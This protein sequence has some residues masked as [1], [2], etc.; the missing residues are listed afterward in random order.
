MHCPVKISKY[1]VSGAD[2]GEKG[3]GAGGSGG[4]QVLGIFRPN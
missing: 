1:K 3:G 4:G 2:P